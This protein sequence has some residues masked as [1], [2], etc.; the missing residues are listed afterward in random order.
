MTYYPS[1]DILRTKITDTTFLEQ[2]LMFLK[3][4]IEGKSKN[5]EILLKQTLLSF[6]HNLFKEGR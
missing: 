3:S 1:H 4:Q 6:G 2:L 5:S